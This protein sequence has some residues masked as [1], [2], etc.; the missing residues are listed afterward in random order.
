MDDQHRRNREQGG[1]LRLVISTFRGSQ[2]ML[3]RTKGHRRLE[4]IFA[5]DAE[6]SITVEDGDFRQLL[7]AAVH[8]HHP[9]L[10]AILIEAVKGGLAGGKIQRSEL[11]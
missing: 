11:E 8:T 1:P 2:H 6:C 4:G 7:H 9:V 5:F 3:I 10:R